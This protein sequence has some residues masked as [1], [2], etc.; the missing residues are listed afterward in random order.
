MRFTPSLA[1]PAARSAARGV[2]TCLP[3]WLPLMKGRLELAWTP[4]GRGVPG[5]RLASGDARTSG[6][7]MHGLATISS[8][9]TTHARSHGQARRQAPPGCGTVGCIWPLAASRRA[10]RA[11]DM[12][13]KGAS[14]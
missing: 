1:G 5:L 7:A 14:P 12:G 11:T 9:H 6:P 13:G 8:S 3:E 4:G 2:S 10:S